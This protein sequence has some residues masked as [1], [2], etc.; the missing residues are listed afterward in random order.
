MNVINRIRTEALKRIDEIFPVN[1]QIVAPCIRPL[2][3]CDLISQ[4]VR[5]QVNIQLETVVTY[6]LIPTEV[7]FG[8]VFDFVGVYRMGVCLPSFC[9]CPQAEMLPEWNLGVIQ[10]PI[11]LPA[12]P[13]EEVEEQ[14]T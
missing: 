13:P 8:L 3:C 1:K 7:S 5:G 9:P 12:P 2:E 14:A 10:P 4:S 6:L 11:P